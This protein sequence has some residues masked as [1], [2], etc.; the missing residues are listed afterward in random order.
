MVPVAWYT[1]IDSTGDKLELKPDMELTNAPFEGQNGVYS[2][3]QYIYSGQPDG[4]LIT[5]LN[6]P[7]LYSP[8]FAISLQFRLDTL[9]DYT[10][11]IMIVGDTWRYLGFY[12]LSDDEWAIRFNGS[13]HAI[14]DIKPDDKWHEVTIIYSSLD[15]MVHFYLDAEKIYE[16]TAPLIRDIEDDRISNT[17]YGTGNT[18]LGNWRHLKIFHSDE[19]F[20]STEHFEKN[21]N[22]QLSPNP[23]SGFILISQEND[24]FDHWEVTNLNRPTP[25]IQ[26]HWSSSQIEIPTGNLPA[27]I[28]VFK[29]TNLKS[30]QIIT[31]LFVK[32]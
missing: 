3:G 4:C 25:I 13:I 14:P 28:Y 22:I 6:I 16:Q 2:N 1:L 19:I 11:P 23:T 30:G 15:S 9:D 8:T 32:Q 12:V 31:K 27:G 18:F 5:T 29:A 17:H 10:R 21:Q 24:R 26:G 7:E 20:S